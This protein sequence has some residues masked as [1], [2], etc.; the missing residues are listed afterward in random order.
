VACGL[1]KGDSADKRGLLLALKEPLENGGH[2]EWFGRNERMYWS[3]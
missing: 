1:V 3:K 2:D